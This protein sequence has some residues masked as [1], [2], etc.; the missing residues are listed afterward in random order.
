VALRVQP[1]DLWY[2]VEAQF[3]LVEELVLFARV[4]GVRGREVVVWR[5]RGEEVC[6]CAGEGC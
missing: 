3:T 4:R 2:N 1:C 6:V 5:G